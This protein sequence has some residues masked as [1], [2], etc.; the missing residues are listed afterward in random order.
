MASLHHN[1]RLLLTTA[2]TKSL[3]C[4]KIDHL[5]DC[6][7]SKYTEKNDV[8]KDQFSLPLAYLRFTY[9]LPKVYLLL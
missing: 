4:A 8:D 9:C 1:N 5:V 2:T 3:V 7:Y 6:M